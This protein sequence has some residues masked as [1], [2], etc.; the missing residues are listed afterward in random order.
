MIK[1]T[2]K[3]LL[4]SLFTVFVIPAMSATGEEKAAAPDT[5]AAVLQV[6]ESS[7]ATSIVDRVPQ[8]VATTFDNEVGKLTCYSK[9]INGGSDGSD[10]V[11]HV[12]YYG[13][14]VMADIKLKLG[15]SSW[16]T[17]SNKTIMKQWKGDWHV[18]IVAPDDTVLKTLNFTVN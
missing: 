9:I 10:H 2:K 12:W 5:A 1:F 15:A 17:H 7:I 14:D 3:F 8:G 6:A 18:D 4:L 13:D 11:R 16:R